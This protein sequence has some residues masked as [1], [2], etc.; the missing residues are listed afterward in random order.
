MD[1]R[2]LFFVAAAI[3]CAALAPPTPDKLRWFTLLLSGIYWLLAAA[4]YLDNR[5]RNRAP[6]NEP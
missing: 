3:A 5:A 4:S 2:A 1:R 6:Q